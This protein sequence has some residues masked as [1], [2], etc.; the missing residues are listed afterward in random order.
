MDLCGIRIKW[1]DAYGT[2]FSIQSSDDAT[3]WQ[4]LINVPGNNQHLTELSL[5]GSGRYVRMLGIKRATEFGYS[6]FEMQVY[7]IPSGSCA[8]PDGLQVTTV[9]Q[10]SAT[11]GWL[12]TRKDQ[13]VRS[14]V[15]DEP[16]TPCRVNR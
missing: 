11:L 4:T 14:A 5:T 7:G 8:T 1:E 16:E 12:P 13:V 3:T 15:F 9:N 10:Q 2:D 6:I